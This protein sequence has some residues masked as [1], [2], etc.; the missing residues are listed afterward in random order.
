MVMPSSA[1]SSKPP[2]VIW[3]TEEGST[4]DTMS[5]SLLSSDVMRV[6]PSAMMRKT[7]FFVLGALAVSQYSS[8]ATKV[9]EAPFVQSTNL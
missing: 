5:H 4:L 1:N 3:F 8:L 2:S 9:T 6:L 7:R